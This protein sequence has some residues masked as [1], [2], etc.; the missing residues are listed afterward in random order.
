MA[1]NGVA[2]KKLVNKSEGIIF[3]EQCESMNDPENDMRMTLFF[4]LAHWLT[5]NNYCHLSACW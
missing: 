3:R 5:R 2:L 4:E 1:A